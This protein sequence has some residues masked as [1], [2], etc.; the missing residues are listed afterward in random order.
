ML[1]VTGACIRD[2][3]QPSPIGRG[4]PHIASSP[5]IHTHTCFFLFTALPS[6]PSFAVFARGQ[7]SQLKPHS[8]VGESWEVSVLYN[9]RSGSG[10]LW[11]CFA[12]QSVSLLIVSATAGCDAI[13]LVSYKFFLLFSKHFRPNIV[14]LP[15][16]KWSAG[17]YLHL[18]R[19]TSHP[20]APHL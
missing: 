11:L 3:C 16:I 20:V 10:R 14:S 5:R 12:E 9:T 15:D 7:R 2:A 6:I 1:P 13:L 17:L 18:T 8:L 4:N 19:S